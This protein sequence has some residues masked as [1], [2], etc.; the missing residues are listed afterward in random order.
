MFEKAISHASKPAEMA[1]INVIKG[2]V[3]RAAL[4]PSPLADS[5]AASGAK[6]SL[7]PMQHFALSLTSNSMLLHGLT[8]E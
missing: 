7:S 3:I 6:A 5:F 8:F 1:W 2:W 4:S